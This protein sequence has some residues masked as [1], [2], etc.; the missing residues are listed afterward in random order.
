MGQHQGRGEP[1]ETQDQLPK[2]H[3]AFDDFFVVIEQDVSEE[4]GEN[5]FLAISMIEALLI[6]VDSGASGGPQARASRQGNA[7]GNAS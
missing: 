7:P 1:Q 5:R 3:G 6:T 2:R 4:Y